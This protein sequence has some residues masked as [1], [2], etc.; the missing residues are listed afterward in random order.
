MP[1]WV[2]PAVAVGL[3]GLGAFVSSFGLIELI[4]R[5]YGTMTIGFILIYVIPVLTLG[6]WKIVQAPATAESTQSQA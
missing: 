4:A 6:V 1:A 3:L 2:R 5:G